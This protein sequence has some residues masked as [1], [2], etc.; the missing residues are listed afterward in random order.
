MQQES[1]LLELKEPQPEIPGERPGRFLVCVGPSPSAFGLVRAVRRLAAAR[2]GEWYALYVE[3]P[4]HER[5]P[6]TQKGIVSQALHLASQLGAKA[7]RA[8]GFRIGPEILSFAREKQVSTIILGKPRRGGPRLLFG[9]S[10][11]DYLVRRC[12]SIDIAILSPEAEEEGEARTISTGGGKISLL[13]FL[14][15]Y[16]L[17]AAG[18]GVCTA[19]AGV[20]YPYLTFTSLVMLYLLTVVVVSVSLSRGPAVFSAGAGVAVFAYFFVPEYWSFRIINPEY[21]IT[22]LVMLGVSA[23][24]SE[25]TARIRYQAR[26][27]RRQERQTAAL[28]ELSQRLGGAEDLPTLMAAAVEHIAGICDGRAAILLPGENGE[29]GVAAGPPLPADDVREAMVASW[30]FRYGHTA[31]AGT[32]TLPAVRGTYVPLTVGDKAVGVL[33]VELPQPDNPGMAESLPL[34]EA[35]ARQLG[36]ALERDKLCREAREAQ[37]A[38]EAER[39]RNALLS[40]VSHDL[41]TPLTVIAG[42]AS[43][44]LEGEEVLDQATKREL[45]Q[46]IYEEANRLDLLV[47]NLLEMS[48]LQS[49]R[50]RVNREWHVLEEVIGNALQQLEPVLQAHPVTITLPP[51]CPLVNM[52]ALLMERVLIN[53][54]DNAMKY[55]PPGTAIDITVRLKEREAVLEVADAGPGL[56]PGNEERI[57]EKFFQSTPGRSRGVGLGLSICRSIIEAHG[58]RIW[59]ANRPGGGAVFSFSLPLLEGAPTLDQELPEMKEEPDH[60]A[61]HPPH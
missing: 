33:R 40:S 9:G 20:L 19:L 48:R 57:F 52:D 58:G 21:L 12:G 61:P 1:P 37:L 17:A 27:A 29:L 47:H 42:S 11:V 56:P 54:L 6:E 44:L 7:V 22:L 24:I 13:G 49:G 38:I 50:L 51:D 32:Q 41:K 36:L 14:R 59:V 4:G 10:P 46:T 26:V 28:Y 15:E 30:V 16:L 43:S 23:L 39:M 2:E 5:L 34:L 18:V 53:L 3:T 35:L 25:L 31:G 55:T 45:T 60:E 8:S